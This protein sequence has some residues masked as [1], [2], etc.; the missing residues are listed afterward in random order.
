MISYFLWPLILALLFSCNAKV[1]VEQGELNSPVVQ[2]ASSINSSIVGTGAVVAAK[3]V[4]VKD[5]PPYAVA[6][7][8]PCKVIRYRFDEETIK[9]LLESEWWNIPP[10]ELTLYDR[11]DPIKFL[12]NFVRSNHTTIWLPNKIQYSDLSLFL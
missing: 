6:G 7:G 3:S 10:A 12:S 9:C 4:V 8:N 5:I 1:W 2:S 11:S